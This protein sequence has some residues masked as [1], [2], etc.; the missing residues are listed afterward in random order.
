MYRDY[1]QILISM[2]HPI[3]SNFDII[4]PIFVPN[5]VVRFNPLETRKYPGLKV[6][7]SLIV[8]FLKYHGTFLKRLMKGAQDEVEGMKLG[9]PG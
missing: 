1:T 3:F 9:W 4:C 7:Y 2:T 5:T 6:T 8:P